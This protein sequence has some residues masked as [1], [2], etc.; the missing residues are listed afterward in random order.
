M[1]KQFSMSLKSHVIASTLGC[2][3]I[4]FPLF[5]TACGDDSS[6]SP[7]SEE[8]S[9]DSSYSEPASSS[10]EEEESSD[11]R[12]EESS[13]SEESS[14][15]EESSSSSE[16]LSSSSSERYAW[17][18]LNKNLSYGE[19]TDERDGTVY[20]TIKIGN[21]TWMAENL[22]RECSGKY[23]CLD[24]YS[25]D[26][27][28][29]G[30]HVPSRKEW[31]TLYGEDVLDGKLWIESG[32][33]KESGCTSSALME[34]TN[35][36][37]FSALPG[38]YMWDGNFLGAGREIEF[39]T[40][41]TTT[42]RDPS[43]GHT[44]TRQVGVEISGTDSDPGIKGM[45]STYLTRSVQFYTRCIMDPE[46]FDYIVNYLKKE[47]ADVPE[48]ACSEALGGKTAYVGYSYKKAV[49]KEDETTHEWAW[50]EETLDWMVKE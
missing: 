11:S 28:P 14:A 48:T 32:C 47:L 19:I 5:L 26:I 7:S 24:Y 15:V 33:T 9:S 39:M 36:T 45:A 22:G 37:G 6:S 2:V 50:V 21:H 49:C 46:G 42:W 35:T 16:E 1:R 40:A 31:M 29:S 30:W 43:T 10:F 12:D 18:H 4:S 23:G 44:Y 25:A 41:D 3:A 34:K 27:C 38:G 13:S 17:Q 8:T 20:K